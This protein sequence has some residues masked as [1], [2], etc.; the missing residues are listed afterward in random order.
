VEDL[1]PD[2]TVEGT[3]AMED[4]DLVVTVEGGEEGV[5]DVVLCKSLWQLMLL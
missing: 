1:N 3:V 4:I 5:E 2:G